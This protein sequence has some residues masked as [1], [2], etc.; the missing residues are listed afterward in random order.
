MVAESDAAGA[1]TATYAYDNRSQLVSMTRGGQTYYYQYNAHGDVVSL[2]D[3]SGQ[4]INIYEYDPW[5][6]VLSSNE[7]IADTRGRTIVDDR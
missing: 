6:K 1:T 3:S 2:T 7:T 4:I 5:G